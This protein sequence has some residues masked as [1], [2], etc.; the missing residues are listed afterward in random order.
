MKKKEVYQY[1]FD[2]GYDIASEN[3]FDYDLK[4]EEQK[5]NFAC[6][7]AEF[8]SSEFRQHSPFEFFAHELNSARNSDELWEEYDDGVWDGIWHRIW[9]ETGLLGD[10]KS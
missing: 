9:E 3:L 5:E 2:T 1:G 7:M 6:D 4:N 8:E 10:K